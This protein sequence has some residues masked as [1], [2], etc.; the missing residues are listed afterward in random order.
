[1]A[2]FAQVGPRLFA[3]EIPQTTPLSDLPFKYNQSDFCIQPLLYAK[4][5]FFA[6]NYIT[7]NLDTD[8]FFSHAIVKKTGRNIYSMKNNCSHDDGGW[9]QHQPT[10]NH[11]L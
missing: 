11:N 1:L 4:F 8:T 6:I 10:V 2:A 3:C 7:S 5:K 9:V